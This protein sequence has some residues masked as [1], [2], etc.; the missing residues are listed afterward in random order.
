M[1]INLPFNYQLRIYCSQ[2]EER[3]G[4]AS[5]IFKEEDKH[6]LLWDFDNI[7][8]NIEL[9]DIM[10]TLIN[11]QTQYNLP[12]I[13][14]VSSSPTNYHAYCFTARSFREVIHIISA[15]PQIDV[16]YL[17]LGMIRGYYTLRISPRKNDN[18]QLIEILESN[19]PDEVN[20][21]DVSVSKYMTINKGGKNAKR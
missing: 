6:I 19:L 16:R 20:P 8:L 11:M 18:F 10:A 17:R 14:V 12:T 21:L 2:R 13:Y 5:K 15:T 1:K 9:A 4:V 3:E 7:K